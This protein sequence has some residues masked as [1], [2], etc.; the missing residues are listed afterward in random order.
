VDQ[1]N[2]DRF[3]PAPELLR[4]ERVRCVFLIRDPKET[5]QSLLDM[6]A[7][8]Y[9][10]W[11][12]QQAVDYYVQRLASLTTYARLLPNRHEAL[13]YDELIRNTSAV[14]RRLESFLGLEEKLRENYPIQKFTG[15]RGDPSEAIR[16]GRI[17]RN[18]KTCSFQIPDS[19]MDRALEAYQA[20]AN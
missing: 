20:C 10:A 9:E 3:M 19:D 2:H 18:Q 8:F 7:K 16:L 12:V 4:E 6:T 14:L 17:V 15:T 5:I 1:I 13:T 11:T